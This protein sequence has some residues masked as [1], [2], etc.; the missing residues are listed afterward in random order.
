MS[1]IAETMRKNGFSEEHIKL[2][3]GDSYN[4]KNKCER[5]EDVTAK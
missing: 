5:V 3:L 4:G 2:T 1:I